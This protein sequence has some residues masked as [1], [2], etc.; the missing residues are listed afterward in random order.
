MTNVSEFRLPD[1]EQRLERAKAAA[2]W[3]LGSSDWA[4]RFIDIYTGHDGPSDEAVESWME[5]PE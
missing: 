5:D 3:E 4:E 1:H 2:R